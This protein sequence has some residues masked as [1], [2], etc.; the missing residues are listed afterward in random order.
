MNSN[1]SKSTSTVPTNIDALASLFEYPSVILFASHFSPAEDNAA[2]SGELA[3]IAVKTID[4]SMICEC[5]LTVTREESSSSNESRR[6]TQE[7]ENVCNNSMSVDTI[8]K[9]L[10]KV[11]P[12]FFFPCVVMHFDNI[13]LLHCTCPINQQT[14]SLINLCMKSS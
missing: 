12:L 4:G 6:V 7:E 8:Q 2:E 10:Q 3:W 14:Y 13:N 9:A 11:G 1:S 5:A